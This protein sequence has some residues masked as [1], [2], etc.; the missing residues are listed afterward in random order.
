VAVLLLIAFVDS[1]LITNIRIGDRA[2][3]WLVVCGWA[4]PAL[5]FAELSLV[6]VP[7]RV[8]RAGGDQS[9]PGAHRR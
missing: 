1:E 7:G 2:L 8:Q 3:L 5:L 9:N 6:Q 4:A